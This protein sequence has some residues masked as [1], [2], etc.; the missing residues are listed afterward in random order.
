MKSLDLQHWKRFAWLMAVT[1]LAAGMWALGPTS[2]ALAQSPITVDDWE[3]TQSLTLT[4]PGVVSS[5]VDGAVILGGERDLRVELIAGSAVTVETAGGDLHYTAD[6]G[7][8]ASALV[9]WDGDDDDPAA[10]DPT[11]LGGVDL[12]GGGA[13][14]AFRLPL[15][16]DESAQITLTVYSGATEV[17]VYAVNFNFGALLLTVDHHVPFADFDGTADFTNVGALVLEIVKPNGGTLVLGDFQALPPTTDL[18]ITK[19][20]YPDPAIAGRSFV[21]TVTVTN[22]GTGPATAVIISD[23]LPTSATINTVDQSDDSL[24]DFD[25]GDYGDHTEW[26]DVRPWPI[27]DDDWLQLSAPIAPTGVYTSRVFD[28]FNLVAWDWLAWTPR[29]PYGKPLPDNGNAETAYELGNADMTGNQVLLHLEEIS[30]TQYT[31]GS[32]IVAIGGIV[33]DTSGN[34]TPAFFPAVLGEEQ[35]PSLVSDGQF[36]NAL[37]FDGS[38]SQTVAI[39]DTTDPARYA[40][41][42][43]VYPEVIADTALILRTDALTSEIAPGRYSHMLGIQGG[44]FV[45]YTNAGGGR[46]VVGNTPVQTNTWYHLVGIAQAGGELR[47]YVNGRE[48]GNP[49]PHLGALW[50]GGDHYRLAAA[51]GPT[52]TM[53]YFSGI[54]DEVAVYSRTLSPEEV[55]DHYLRGALDMG[56]QV[57]ACDDDICDG[58]SFAGP[59]GDAAAYYTE[60]NAAG[61]MP[62]VADLTVPDSRFIQYQVTLHTD[63]TTYTPQLRNVSLGPAHR[64]VTAT[65]GSC[66]GDDHTFSCTV[67]TLL[68]GQVVTVSTS[69]WLDS[70]ALGWIT[71]TASVTTTS[72]DVDPTNNTAT[73]SSSVEAEV[74]LIVEKYDEEYNGGTDPVSPGSVM[75]YTLFIRNAGPSVARGVTVTDEFT[76]GTFISAT[77]PD[78]WAPCQ[79]LTHVLTCT[80]SLLNVEWDNWQETYNWEE[81]VVTAYAPITEGVVTNTVWVTG[82]APELDVTN[83]ITVQDTLITP[84]A[85]IRVN[86]VASADQ[87]DPGAL[88]VYTVTVTNDGPYTATHVVLTDTLPTEALT[89]TVYAGSEWSCG[90]PAAN[91]VTCTLLFELPA[92]A[93][94]GITLTAVAPQSGFISNSAHAT[95]T[96]YDL[97]EDNNWAVVYTF[98]RPV[99]DLAISKSDTPDPVYAADPLTY[100][101]T[102]TNTGPAAAGTVTTT[103][104]AGTGQAMRI[105]IRPGE[106]RPYRTAVWVDNVPGVI[107]NLTVT[108]RGLTHSYPGDLGILLVGPRG[109]NVVLMGNAGGGTDVN[110]LDIVFHQNGAAIADPITADTVYRPTNNGLSEDF[111]IDGP[112]GNS[113]ASFYGTDPN[114]QWHLYII[115]TV[116]SDQGILANGWRLELTTVTDDTIIV[117]DT[118]PSGLSVQG[119]VQTTSAWACTGSSDLTCEAVYLDVDETATFEF[120]VTAPITG[121]II[122]NTAGITATTD[123]FTPLNNTAVET[124]TVIPVADLEMVKSVD[125]AVVSRGYPLTYTLVVNNLGPSQVLTTVTLTDNLPAVLTNVQVISNGWT[126]D[127]S[128]LPVL[129]CTLDGLTAA[130]APTLTLTAN[131]PLT[132]GAYAN[133]AAVAAAM[134]DDDLLNNTDTVTVTVIELPIT[135]LMADNDSPTYIG[136]E[137]HLWA[138]ATPEDNVTYTWDFG[139]GVTDAGALVTYTYPVTGV[140]T[141]IVTATNPANVLTATTIVTINDMPRVYFNTAAYS[142]AENAGAATITVTLQDVAA[143]TVTVDYATGTGTATADVDYVAASGTLTFAPGSTEATFQVSINDDLLDEN[144]EIVPLTLSN[145]SAPALLGTPATATLTILDNDPPPALSVNSV[146]ADETDGVM[147][148]TVS[149]SAVSALDISV[150]YNTSDGTATDGADYIGASGTLL[151]APGVI[152]QTISV[153]VLDDTVDEDDETFTL[154]LS[155]PLHATLANANGIGTIVDD[156]ITNLPPVAVDD[157]YTTPEDTPLVVTALEG[158]LANDTDAEAAPL[159]ATLGVAPVVGVLDFAA[160]GSFV[161][162]PTLDFFGVVTFTYTAS[163]GVNVSNVALVTITV[164]S[165]ND[166]PIAVDDAYTTPED[167]PLPITAPGVLANDSDVDGPAMSAVLDDAPFN[168]VLVLAADGGFVYTPTLDFFGVDTFTYHVSDGSDISNIATVTITVTAANDAPIAAADVYTTRRDTPLHVAMPGV[169]ANDTDADNTGLTATLNTN[170]THGA[171]TLAVDGSFVYTPTAGYVGVDSFTYH[172]T[173]GQADSAVVAVTI[174]V[175]PPPLHLIYLPLVMRNYA[176][177]PDLVVEQLLVST[178]QVVVVIRNQGEKPVEADIE[179]EFWVDVYINP[180]TPPTAVNQTWRHCGSQ[181]LVWGVTVDAFPLD[182]GEV[183]TLTT[184]ATGGPFPYFRPDQSVV[185]WTLPIGA[186]IWAQVDSADEATTYGGVEENHE[187][188]GIAYNNITGPVTVTGARRYLGVELTAPVTAPTSDHLPQRP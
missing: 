174:N 167:T 76:A 135:G 9:V 164:T 54:L 110:D 4:V 116:Y 83:N 105:H 137:T 31:T 5:T 12:T 42:L 60:L 6:T 139:N 128:A 86:K 71:N 184:A 39:S 91:V 95:A 155:A 134:D 144:D 19:E 175:T 182:P 136:D 66:G 73:I 38:L 69:A 123:D 96:Q 33:T 113:L 114:G 1:V 15:T 146:S 62:L 70:A 107:Q 179:N 57:R 143:V 169:L 10:F 93:S 165:V 13:L 56:F 115:D 185:T 126:C 121:G 170:V 103:V 154:T 166:L 186:Q 133:T 158:V 77:P 82:I 176:T 59:N 50:A 148:F 25:Q 160:D 142:V 61:P 188:S 117:T 43:W 92:G 3:T 138:V 156:D 132:L 37:H 159:T 141:A 41:E 18:L 108:L 157:A 28:A 49:V 24:W 22:I 102:V 63:D 150:V 153:T 21:Y 51:Y 181:G 85:D 46:T 118:L 48:D 145:P 119:P 180:T 125:P 14:N 171:L 173:D 88:L 35:M 90:W 36:G 45:H 104:R 32:I 152:S 20:V 72:S 52:T 53:T 172:A 44:R 97:N 111:R 168:G 8:W 129:T 2:P 67:G 78:G 177:G 81:I 100:T 84:V 34:A 74:N 68:P 47:L 147:T 162:T 106:S 120:V 23:T 16:L 161:Y 27:V 112:Y 7:A 178:N 89:P 122:T 98:I 11:G 26:R 29:Q 149:L 30:Y 80:T 127:V 151:L 124:T 140:F 75:T 55:R 163:D 99:A 131:A 101:L 87:V 64:V 187:R 65:Q 58:E 40:L 79:V 183:L 94:A 109:Q 130:S 17:S